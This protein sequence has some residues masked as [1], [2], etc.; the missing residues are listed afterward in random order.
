[1]I[2][3]AALSG[4]AV[5]VLRAA[6]GRGALQLALLVGGLFA[7]GVLYG[8]QAGAAEGIA[9]AG[10]V[11]SPVS[12]I[13][14]ATVGATGGAGA[15][16]ADGREDDADRVRSSDPTSPGDLATPGGLAESAGL[17]TLTDLAE[18]VALSTPGGFAEPADRATGSS[19]E[20]AGHPRDGAPQNRSGVGG[21]VE[22]VV[23]PVTGRA[24][25]AGVQPLVG[26]L[27]ASVDERV[28]RPVGDV[29]ETV[30]EGLA[31]AGAETPEP[32]LPLPLPGLSE[33]P[34]LPVLP[35]LPG[36][37]EPSD[38]TP[39]LPVLPELPGQILPLPV[40]G[41]SGPGAVVQTSPS[42]DVGLAGH[43]GTA[44]A[45]TGHGPR[46]GKSTGEAGRVTS[47]GDGRQAHVGDEY[48]A[49]RHA[50]GGHGDGVLGN[51]SASD[52]GT[53]RHFD[54]H[55]VAV[56]PRAPLSLV[57]GAVEGV[58]VDGTKDRHRDI[59]VFPG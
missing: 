16:D 11:T 8:E 41:E 31:R 34:T 39:A 13:V 28:V 25:S 21:R 2:W 1:M 50:P 35:N 7:L 9:G 45:G 17:A 10:R 55:A 24:V 22:Q 4:A 43:G 46:L 12:A 32:L 37:A 26:S 58:E 14:T 23:R 40:G 57:A 47:Q 44:R 29:V 18:P 56:N 59:P 27:G 15:T 20:S 33:S 30:T 5:R 19:P 42:A 52:N 6:A 36:A 49:V 53:S 48:A 54:G 51:R 38:P 3:S